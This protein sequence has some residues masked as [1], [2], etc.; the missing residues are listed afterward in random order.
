MT[1][2]SASERIISAT[3][4]AQLLDVHHFTISRMVENGDLAGYKITP[5]RRNSPLCIY[6]N[7]AD[8]LLRQW[9][10]QP[11]KKQAASL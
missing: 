7:S 5:S 8:E 6:R 3:K 2:S 11:N 4:A 1:T 9:R 10:R